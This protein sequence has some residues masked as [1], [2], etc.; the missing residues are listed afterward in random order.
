MQHPLLNLGVIGFSAEQCALLL[1]QLNLNRTE[2]GAGELE[3][4]VWQMTDYR[5]AN[6]LLV[7]AQHIAAVDAQGLHFHAGNDDNAMVGLR[8]S[9]LHVPYAISGTL[10]PEMVALTGRASPHTELHDK[11]SVIRTLQYFEAALRPLRTAFALACHMA[12][13]TAE[14]DEQHVFH[15][16]RDNQ[17][18]AILDVPMQ[19]VM[20]RQGLRPMDLEEAIWSPRPKS[21]NSLPAGFVVWA[22]EEL[23]WLLAM[24]GASASVPSRYFSKLIYLRRMPHLRAHTLY[25]RHT[26][27]LELLS[28]QGWKFIDLLAAVGYSDEL[29]RRDLYALYLCHAITTTARKLPSGAVPSA[30]P[31]VGDGHSHMHTSR[32]DDSFQLPTMAADLR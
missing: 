23:G 8:P 24:H 20:V 29:L 30:P 21:A 11:R 14:L 2:H 22:T 7:N 16:E 32:L 4:P 5:E 15:I 17:L 9:E 12:E 13:R 18:Q 1:A 25:P 27:L 3:H 6:A 26:S 19:R 31:S 28:Q 10:T